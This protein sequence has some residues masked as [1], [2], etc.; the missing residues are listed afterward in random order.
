MFFM[1]Q[2]L[3]NIVYA[4]HEQGNTQ[5]NSFLTFEYFLL[6]QTRE[7]SRANDASGDLC[8]GKVFDSDL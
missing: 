5:N 4:E 7:L 1:L 8:Y 3:P 2:L 6:I